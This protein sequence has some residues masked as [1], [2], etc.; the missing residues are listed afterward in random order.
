METAAVAQEAATREIPFLAVRVI[1]DT[2]G[3]PF[4][5]TLYFCLKP[6]SGKRLSD[7]L[8]AI[9]PVISDYVSRPHTAVVGD[10]FDERDYCLMTKPP[11][12]RGM[13]SSPDLQ[14]ELRVR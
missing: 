2:V 1:A 4:G 7:A 10:P 13:P 5:E 9:L 11:A 12:K 3:S 14:H 6:L 8:R